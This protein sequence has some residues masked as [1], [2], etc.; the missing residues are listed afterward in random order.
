LLDSYDSERRHVGKA[1]AEQ[2][3]VRNRIR[4]GYADEETRKS[5]VDDIIVTLGYRYQSPMVTGYDSTVAVLSAKPILTGE[6][7]TR[8][9]HVWLD[10]NGERVSTIDL[11]WGEFVLLT[12][13]RDNG[14]IEAA[15]RAAKQLSVPVQIHVIGAEGDL[16]PQ[17]RDWARAYGVPA[18]GAVLVR[19][20]AFVSWRSAGPV[21]NQDAL[22]AAVLS[23]ATGRA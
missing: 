6:P 5:M 23:R 16:V 10:R 9:P 2:A 22:F 19:P 3:M 14:W 1:M 11:F 15:E 18:D 13:S 8:A 21:D 4:H 12:G 20:D 7:G 17:D